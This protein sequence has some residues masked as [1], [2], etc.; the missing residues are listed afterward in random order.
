[1]GLNPNKRRL[2][3][4]LD[5]IGI[6]TNGLISITVHLDTL[7][8]LYT[9]KGDCD[10]LQPSGWLQEAR[11]ATHLSQRPRS[12]CFVCSSVTSLQITAV[13]PITLREAVVTPR[14]ALNF[15]L[16]V[17]WLQDLMPVSS[18]AELL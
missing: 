15:Y 8:V 16:R 4:Y 14:Y 13:R 5:A 2:H 3:V 18:S 12:A 10:R 9:P 11:T 7:F 17:P 1:L 6:T